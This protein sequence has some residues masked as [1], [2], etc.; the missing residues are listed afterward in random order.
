M[1]RV[2]GISAQHR[3]GMSSLH[4]FWTGR[5]TAVV[6]SEQNLDLCLRSLTYTTQYT[7]LLFS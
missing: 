1:I 4:S 7:Y 2:M 6:A 3:K 5:M